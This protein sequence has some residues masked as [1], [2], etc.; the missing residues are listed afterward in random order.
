MQ[1]QP[2]D[3]E[4]THKVNPVQ[5]VEFFGTKK[6]LK[7]I[8]MMFNEMLNDIY[9]VSGNAS[10]KVN[11]LYSNEVARIYLLNKVSSTAKEEIGTKI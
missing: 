10:G 9:N 1:M 5:K 3:M 2:N 11:Q 7:A 6:P 4:T 8:N